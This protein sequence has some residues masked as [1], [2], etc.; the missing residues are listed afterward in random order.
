VSD[1]EQALAIL[2]LAA[3][4]LLSRSFFLLADREL[5]LPDWAKR[6]LKYAPLAALV[7]ICVPEVVM[8]QGQLLGTLKD[9][10]LLAALAAG[11]YYFWRHGI[12]GTI[13]TGMAVFLPLR[14]GLGW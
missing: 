12:L 13:V 2:G 4:T 3:L 7:A 9:A 6:A 5:A 10:R 14:I 1:V 11:A 8:A